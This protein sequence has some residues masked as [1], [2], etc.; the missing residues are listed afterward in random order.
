MKALVNEII[1]NGLIYDLTDKNIKID[2][3][4][5]VEYTVY[6]SYQTAIKI[7]T[8]PLSQAMKD[9]PIDLPLK[10]FVIGTDRGRFALYDRHWRYA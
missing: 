2:I 8:T 4:E 9:I 3:T 10:M 1:L 7:D 5:E 6:S